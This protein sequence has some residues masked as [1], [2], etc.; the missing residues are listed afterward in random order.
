MFMFRLF[1]FLR[2][3]SPFTTSIWPSVLCARLLSIHIYFHG[4]IFIWMCNQSMSVACVVRVDRRWVTKQSRI[5]LFHSFF[6]RFCLLLSVSATRLC[7]CLFGNNSNRI[8]GCA[9]LLVRIE[10]ARTRV[11]FCIVLDYSPLFSLSQ[12]ETIDSHTNIMDLPAQRDKKTHE[13]TQG[14]H[15]SSIGSSNDNE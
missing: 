2:Y 8:F 13:E 3:P 6:F 1:L 9:I 10:D 7:R 14:T 5:P 15:C 12:L 11:A 4:L